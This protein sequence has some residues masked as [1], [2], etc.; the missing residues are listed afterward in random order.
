MI[1]AFAL[2]KSDEVRMRQTS[3]NSQWEMQ[4]YQND[5]QRWIKMS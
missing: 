2:N 5:K 4:G 3:S 1:Y